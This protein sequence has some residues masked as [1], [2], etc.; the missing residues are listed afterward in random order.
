SLPGANRE[1]WS[2][3]AETARRLRWPADRLKF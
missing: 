3:T 2:W 1:A